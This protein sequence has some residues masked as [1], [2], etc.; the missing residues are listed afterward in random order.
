MT[1]ITLRELREHLSK[2]EFHRRLGVGSHPAAALPNAV[3]ISPPTMPL[4]VN[5]TTV[6]S[7]TSFL[8]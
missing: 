4:C 2:T 3:F 5:F 7:P 8:M 1:T 6:Q